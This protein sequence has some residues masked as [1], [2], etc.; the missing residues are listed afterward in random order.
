MEAAALERQ[1]RLA[2]VPF[3]ADD[4]ACS[5]DALVGQ[6]VFTLYGASGVPAHV[7]AGEE[8]TAA[9]ADEGRR[10]ADGGAAL[11]S[12]Y[13][14]GGDSDGGDAGGATLFGTKV[15]DAEPDPEAHA[16]AAAAAKQWEQIDD[17]ATG[18]ADAKPMSQILFE[19]QAEAA[20]V[21]AVAA[22][23]RAAAA[24]AA[25][26]RL[27]LLEEEEARLR[28]AQATREAREAAAARRRRRDGDDEGRWGRAGSEGLEAGEVEGDVAE[29]AGPQ[30]GSEEHRRQM[31][32]VELRVRARAFLQASARPAGC[33]AGSDLRRET[34]RMFTCQSAAGSWRV[35]CRWWSC[36]R[37]WRSRAWRRASS[38]SGA[39]RCAS[40]CACRWPA[41]PTL[42]PRAS[43]PLPA[44]HGMGARAAETLSGMGGRVLRGRR[45]RRRAGGGTAIETGSAGAGRR[46][47]LMTTG[48][49]RSGATAPA[50]AVNGAAK[51][52]M[53]ACAATI[54]GGAGRVIGMRGGTGMA[55]GTTEL[56]TRVRVGTGP[57]TG[58]LA[59]LRLAVA[60]P[61]GIET[62]PRT[63][64]TGLASGRAG[65]GGGAAGRRCG[66]APLRRSG[67]AIL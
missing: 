45:R 47:G 5:V 67:L 57:A 28:A 30:A 40:S 11:V 49:A 38:H 14:S 8:G 56:L 58:H 60:L 6:R 17:E 44:W 1:C 52:M 62:A 3:H 7:L 23:E 59:L 65:S 21:A 53:T 18:A 29:A 64:E 15:A 54:A 39:P 42:R 26:E 12:G 25:Q 24:A 37:S 43:A 33:F 16:R 20:R 22:A 51:T 50:S 34:R 63:S 46:S 66:P 13:G 9:G 10:A 41:A 19:R 61:L 35:C 4:V 48:A 32:E 31:R 36:R 27:R 55:G 2:G